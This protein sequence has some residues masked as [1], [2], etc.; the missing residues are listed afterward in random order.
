MVY[1][2]VSLLSVYCCVS[3]LSVYCCVSLLSV[4][5]CVSL[6]SVYCCVS[7]LSVGQEDLRLLHN[8]LHP[9]SDKWFSLGIQLQV[10][11]ETLKHIQS[12]NCTTAECLLEMLTVWL[13][14]IHPPHTWDILIDALESPPVGEMAL[15][16]QLRAKYCPQTERAIH[17]NS[18]Q[19][20]HANANL[21]PMLL[22]QIFVSLLWRKFGVESQFLL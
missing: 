4:Y 10:S 8:E 11:F 21:E 14:Q 22:F 18:A 1:C 20:V 12:D 2:C 15:A 16:D 13:K 19:G 17:G 5:C 9:V 7:L 3:L 6:L